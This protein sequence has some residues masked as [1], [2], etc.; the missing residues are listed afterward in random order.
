ME[1]DDEIKSNPSPNS[2]GRITV[3]VAAA[4]HSSRSL[5][6]VTDTAEQTEFIDGEEFF[7]LCCDCFVSHAS[8][9]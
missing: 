1:D 2:N 3:T 9:G 5:A 6:D 4:P 7:G 8:H